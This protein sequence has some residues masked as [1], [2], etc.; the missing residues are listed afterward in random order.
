MSSSVVSKS[1][2]STSG[3]KLVPSFKESQTL[4]KLK[5]VFDKVD[6]SKP[7]SPKF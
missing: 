7:A 6:D 5:K 2:I 4:M 1:V 3:A